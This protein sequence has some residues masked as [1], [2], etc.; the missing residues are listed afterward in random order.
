MVLRRCQGESSSFVFWMF[1]YIALGLPDPLL[2][3][4]PMASTVEELTSPDKILGTKFSI[5]NTSL[6]CLTFRVL[7][8]CIRSERALG[9]VLLQPPGWLNAATASKY[10]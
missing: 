4:R 8:A 3:G 1:V 6:L 10:S 5:D 2:A 9:C 7:L